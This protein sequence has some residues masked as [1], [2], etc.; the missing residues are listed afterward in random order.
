M[1]RAERSMGMASN[2]AHARLMMSGSTMVAGML[3]AIAGLVLASWAIFAAAPRPP[4]TAATPVRESIRHE[5]FRPVYALTCAVLTI[6]LVID[7]MK[8]LTL[9]FVLPG[10]R[11]EYG[12]S[13]DTVSALSVVALTG[14]AVGSIIWGLLGDRYGRRP[15][16]LLATLIFIATSACGAMP[17]FQ[18]NLVMCFLMGASA[19]GLLP[20][21]FTLVAELTPASH[22]GWIAV[23]IGS[24]GG[25]GGYLAASNA[26]R[27]LEPNYTWRMLWLIGL[28]M[29]WRCWR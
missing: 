8:P 13:L 22:R 23:S 14:T 29:V 21:V 2:T 15:V 27:F 4:R 6:A 11:Q 3:L 10:L 5:R 28:P 19:G 12:L 9:A 17:A 7:V 16:L 25:L 1:A 20:L 26:A 18:W 24:V